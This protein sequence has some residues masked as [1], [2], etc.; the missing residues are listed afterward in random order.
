MSPRPR[1]LPNLDGGSSEALNFEPFD[2]VSSKSAG[3]N[4]A[5]PRRPDPFRLKEGASRS[6]PGSAAVGAR[7]DALQSLI[8][9]ETLGG[10]RS[11]SKRDT[12][13]DESRELG[14]SGSGPS[15]RHGLANLSS[16][17]P[18]PPKPRSL[19]A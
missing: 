4:G 15:R 8:P 13:L 1:I 10:T 7:G 19:A 12:R 18:P 16:S 11:A 6:S 17:N 3:P 14:R 5:S 2:Q 9:S